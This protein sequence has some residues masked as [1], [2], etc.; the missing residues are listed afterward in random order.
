MPT[1][2]MIA[3]IGEQPIPNLLPIRHDKPKEVLLVRTDRTKIVGDRLRKILEPDVSVFFCDVDP[4][5]ISAIYCN[6]SDRV[7]ELGWSSAELIF[8]L[9]GGTK[10]MAFAAYH[11]ALE[12][13]ESQFLYLESERGKSRFR[14]YAFEDRSATLKRDEIIPTVIT[15]DD[16]LTAHLGVYQSYNANEP[17][18]QLLFEVLKNEMDEVMV[19]VKN[20]RGT[21]DLDLVVRIGNQV[22][23]IEAKTGNKAR[24]KEGIDQLN[25]AG[26][27]AY[28]GIYTKKFLI[29]DS[30]WEKLTNLSELAIARNIMVIQ[31]SSYGQKK[32]LSDDDKQHLIQTIKTALGGT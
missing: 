19:A 11:L 17:F 27:R 22:G 10:A 28:L 8:N 12:K 30:S 7:E 1:K 24:K 31:L 4:Y 25:T 5:D 21:L 2:K 13:K 20:P 15:I 18:E 6:L 3:L 23:I 9:T 26:G 29:V 16:Y 32:L 14:Q